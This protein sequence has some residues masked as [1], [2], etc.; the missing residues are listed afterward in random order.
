VTEFLIDSNVIIDV[1]TDDPVWGDWSGE[2]MARCADQGRLAINPT[3]Y[4]F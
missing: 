2:T 1:A 4:A 3:I